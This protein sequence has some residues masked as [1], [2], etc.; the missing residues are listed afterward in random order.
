MFLE[1][2]YIPFGRPQVTAV[3]IRLVGLT[4]GIRLRLEIGNQNLNHQLAQIGG[5]HGGFFDTFQ[6]I[7]V[8]LDGIVTLLAQGFENGINTVIGLQEG[9]GIELGVRSFKRFQVPEKV[10]YV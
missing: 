1:E 4:V 8:N 3:E 6:E 5:G 9:L 7:A 10:L 2:G